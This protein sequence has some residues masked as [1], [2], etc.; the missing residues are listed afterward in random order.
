LL[1]FFAHDAAKRQSTATIQLSVSEFRQKLL[2]IPMPDLRLDSITKAFPPAPPVLADTSL[3]VESGHI[4]ALMG[5][6]GCGKTTLLRLIAGL[7]RPLR[8][9]ILLGDKD[10]ASIPPHERNVALVFQTPVLYPQ[11]SVEQ[12]MAI[13]AELRYNQQ[14]AWWKRAQRP[15]DFRQRLCE[16]ADLLEL[17][18][19]LER[20]PATLSGGE[21]QRVAL[22]R[23]L[24]RRPAVFLLDEPLA[25]LD[26]D[27]AGRLCQRL[28]DWFKRQ[29]ATVVW[30]TH[31]PAEAQAVGDWIALLHQGRLVEQPGTER[32]P[33]PL[34]GRSE[35]TAPSEGAS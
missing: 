17:T 15:D 27:L 13:A 1:A 25:Y 6:S 28:R 35:P 4:L 22:G 5:P 3:H 24:L 14:K 33:S 21:R 2:L 8:G 7:E 31:L 12:N 18:R 20:R 30:V 10:M 23:A 29:A 32:G 34:L 19:L 11:L 9:N 26:Q 16:V